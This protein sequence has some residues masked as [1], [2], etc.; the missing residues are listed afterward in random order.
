M[1]YKKKYGIAY[2]EMIINGGRCACGR[3]VACIVAIIDALA[4]GHRSYVRPVGVF[5]VKPQSLGQGQ[6]ASPLLT[7]RVGCFSTFF[8]SKKV[9]DCG[10]YSYGSTV[11]SPL[12]TIPLL[13]LQAFERR[14]PVLAV[15]I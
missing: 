2:H 5:Y 9:L 4:S 10:G 13:G 14:S 7:P 1:L 8:L 3:L 11:P 12:S 15:L 6:F